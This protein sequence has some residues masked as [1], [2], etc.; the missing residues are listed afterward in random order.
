MKKIY[1]KQPIYNT[2][3]LKQISYRR[4]KNDEKSIY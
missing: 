1:A 3:N 2:N 4:I